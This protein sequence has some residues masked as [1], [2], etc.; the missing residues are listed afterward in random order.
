[1]RPTSEGKRFLLATFLVAAAALNSGNNLIYLILAMMLSI[2]AVS[3][4]ALSI[5]L[6]GLSLGVRVRQPVF[7]LQ[8]AYMEIRIRNSK[9]HFSSYSLRVLPGGAMEGE[10]FAAHVPANTGAVLETGVLFRKRGVYQYGDFLI[11]SGFPFIFFSRKIKARLEGEITVYPELTAVEEFAVVH[12]K[13]EDAVAAMRPGRGDDLLTIRELREGDDT[14]KIHWKASAKAE[15]LMVKE[16]GEEEPGTVTIILD[17]RAPFDADAFERAVSYA[18][19]YA[20]MLLDRG[21]YVSLVTC[22]KAL[23]PGSGTDHLYKVLD[24]LALAKEEEGVCPA[25]ED[26]L[27]MGLLI[28]KSDGSALKAMM[29]FCEKVVYA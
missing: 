2:L 4:L 19:S 8:R 16:S 7:A 21:F 9:R 20:R 24:V 27:G 13:D 11:E 6:G 29:P 3:Y 14:G 10:G 15:K 26:V 5:N 1:M 23:P 18:A 22:S 12:G 28:L 17:D 25:Q